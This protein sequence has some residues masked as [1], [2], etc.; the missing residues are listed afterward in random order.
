MEATRG[1]GYAPAWGSLVMMMMS[2]THA[3]TDLHSW[4]GKDAHENH[5]YYSDDEQNDADDETNDWEHNW[6]DS[7]LTSPCGSSAA[8]EWAITANRRLRSV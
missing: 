6:S 2:N 4:C 1:N 3:Y 7:K 8:F 5:H